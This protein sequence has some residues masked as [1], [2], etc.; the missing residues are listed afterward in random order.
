MSEEYRH[1]DVEK[2][3]RTSLL[4]LGACIIYASSDW[5]N[6]SQT[7]AA[8]SARAILKALEAED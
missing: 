3:M 5:V 2:Q 1:V 7:E 8:A 6:Q 4:F